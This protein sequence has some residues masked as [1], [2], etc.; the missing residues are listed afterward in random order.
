MGSLRTFA[1]TGTDDS[2]ADKTDLGFF[3]F[4]DAAFTR[5]CS[6][7]LLAVQRISPERPFKLPIRCQTQTALS[8]H[9]HPKIKSRTMPICADAA[10]ADAE[11]T[12]AK[13]LNFAAVEPTSPKQT[14]IKA[15]SVQNVSRSFV[16]IDL[17]K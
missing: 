16:A 8:L 10:L 1:A 12:C 17:D 5:R 4:A 9:K 6:G 7:N 11:N 15:S 2:N 3:A 14:F 13:G